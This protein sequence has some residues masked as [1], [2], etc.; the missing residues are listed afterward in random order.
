MMANALILAVSMIACSRCAQWDDRSYPQPDSNSGTTAYPCDMLIQKM[1]QAVATN[2]AF[3]RNEGRIISVTPKKLI[4]LTFETYDLLGAI[5]RTIEAIEKKMLSAYKPVDFHGISQ[6]LVILEYLSRVIRYNFNNAAKEVDDILKQRYEATILFQKWTFNALQ[7]INSLMNLQIDT[8]KQWKTVLSPEEGR[9][10]NS[11]IDLNA[12]ADKALNAL[13][14]NSI[15]NYYD[16][17]TVPNNTE[18]LYAINYKF[19]DAFNEAHFVITDKFEQGSSNYEQSALYNSKTFDNS[20]MPTIEEFQ[21][22]LIEDSTRRHEFLDNFAR[23]NNLEFTTNE[24]KLYIYGFD[25]EAAF[26]DAVDKIAKGKDTFDKHVKSF[27]SMLAV[28]NGTFVAQYKIWLGQMIGNHLNDRIELANDNSFLKDNPLTEKS[29]V[30]QKNMVAY[31]KQSKT[32]LE[33]RIAGYNSQLYSAY[34]AAINI[35]VL[36][37]KI[38]NFILAQ[39]PHTNQDVNYYSLLLSVYNTAVET[40]I[41]VLKETFKDF[42]LKGYENKP[43]QLECTDNNSYNCYTKSI[44]CA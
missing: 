22:T 43:E 30:D 27:C 41:F 28:L 31:K 17:Y 44:S 14:E 34:N 13:K 3:S 23:E 21:D 19:L 38:T 35:H 4:A 36:N 33:G 8:M 26:E 39:I 18:T 20:R 37:V 5:Q 9:L 32:F 16:N 11:V 42:T 15:Y 10:L 7:N 12:Q 2:E 6:I 24:E 40:A 25:M 29:T 1:Q